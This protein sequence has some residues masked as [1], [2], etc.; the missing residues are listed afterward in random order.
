MLKER[1]NFVLGGNGGTDDFHPSLLVNWPR[2]LATSEKMMDDT[3]EWP[4]RIYVPRHMCQ[5]CP[6]PNSILPVFVHRHQHSFISYCYCCQRILFMYSN[7]DR[8][9]ISPW[10]VATW[11]MVSTGFNI[12]R[13]ARITPLPYIQ[14][15][16]IQM[17]M[18]VGQQQNINDGRW[19]WH[20]YIAAI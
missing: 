7:D 9:R 18:K 4:T 8:D 3:A 19:L 12:R 15:I 13:P 2:R 11:P 14:P 20:S 1:R 5:W 17:T 10:N 6:W 16:Q